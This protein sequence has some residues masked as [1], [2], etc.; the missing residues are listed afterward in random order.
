MPET[1]RLYYTEP[2]SSE[3][4]AR[5]IDCLKVNGTTGI[6][7]DRTAFYPEGGGQPSDRGEIDGIAVAAV[8]EIDGR[9]VHF[10]A[11][12]DRLRAG[13]VVQG[14]IDWPRRFDHMQQHA[15]QHIL[16]AAFEKVLDADTVGFHLGEEVVTI[17]LDRPSLGRDEVQAVEGLANRVIWENRPI[18][19]RWMTGEDAAALPLR[20]AP[21]RGEGIR[22]VEVQGFDYSPCGGTHPRAAGE[23]GLVLVRRWE[24]SRQ[25]TR[26]EFLCGGRAL[27]DYRWKNELVLQEAG[28]MSV[29]DRDLGKALSRLREEN[30][31]LYRDLEAVRNELL[32]AEAER[33]LLAAAPQGGYRIVTAILDRKPDALKDLA[34]RIAARG[35]IALLGSGNDGAR[36]SFACPPSFPPATGLHVGKLLQEAV[37]LVQGK[38]GGAATAAQGGGPLVEALPAALERAVAVLREILDR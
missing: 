30:R 29:R 1:E 27:A 17:D 12:P 23:I 14:R 11:V 3:F 37:A 4:S 9:V 28:I 15:G 32:D 34:A 5:V 33:L 10:L 38:G 31:E 35:G 16:S 26:V 8:Q 6:V 13:P 2:Y 36:L 20:K 18:S 19:A 25:N 22:I 24:K 21:P 7:L